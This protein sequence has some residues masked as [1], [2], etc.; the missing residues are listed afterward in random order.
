[1]VTHAVGPG[2]SALHE[3]KAFSPDS[4]WQA[5]QIAELY[6]C[7]ERRLDYLG[8]WH[9]HPGG[10]AR[11]SRRDEAT[12]VKIASTR[13]ARCPEPVM[14]ILGSRD[15]ASADWGPRVYVLTGRRSWFS[16]TRGTQ[17]ESLH[18]GE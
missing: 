17:E 12:L 11:P 3:P 9:T 1:V 5:A 4:E 2:P 8:D 18:M 6:E 14:V 13:S 15:G 7:S 10:V 16:W